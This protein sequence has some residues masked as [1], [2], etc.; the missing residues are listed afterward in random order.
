MKVCKSGPGGKVSC[1]PRARRA[2]N[3]AR[4]RTQRGKSASR[5]MVTGSRTNTGSNKKVLSAGQIV[6]FSEP[7]KTGKER[8]EERRAQRKKNERASQQRYSN[9]RFM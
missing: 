3:R 4:R 5:D 7:K 8:R 1:P 6:N 2:A 9:P